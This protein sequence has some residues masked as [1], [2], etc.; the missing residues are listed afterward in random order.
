MRY[1]VFS[2]EHYYP[3]GGAYDF[4]DAFPADCLD[5]AKTLCRL[6]GFPHYKWAHIFD[7]EAQDRIFEV[8]SGKERP[9]TRFI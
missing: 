1:L 8:E 2:G 5:S 7:L 3:G 4:V 6:E 9:V